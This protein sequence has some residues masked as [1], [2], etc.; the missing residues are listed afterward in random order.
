MGA[1][2]ATDGDVGEVIRAYRGE[3]RRIA[4]RRTGNAFLAD[5]A[6]QD[7]LMIWWNDAARWDP[8]RGSIK[9][10]LAVLTDHRAVDTV[11]KEAVRRRP[12]PLA[13]SLGS[14]PAANVNLAQDLLRALKQLPQMEREVLFLAYYA[15]FTYR[16]VAIHL[17][18]PEGTA[19]TRMRRGLTRLRALLEPQEA[20]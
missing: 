8:A 13:S 6:V 1:P 4:R 3:L 16:Q 14:D 11:R 7:A 17:R 12:V 20:S 15:G 5:E 18:I 9:T 2:A 19:K 10:F